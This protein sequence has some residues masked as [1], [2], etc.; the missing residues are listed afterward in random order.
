MT[1][2]KLLLI[3]TFSLYLSAFQPLLQD[4]CSKIDVELDIKPASPESGGSIKV[5]LTRGDRSSVKYIFCTDKEGQVLNEGDF[6]NNELLDLKRGR[7]LCIVSTKD[8][9]KKI[10]FTIE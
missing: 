4:N 1:T 6:K 2:F 3:C 5:N 8:C 7:Y 9:T 10:E